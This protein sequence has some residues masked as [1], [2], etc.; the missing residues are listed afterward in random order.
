M[1]INVQKSSN[2]WKVYLFDLLETFLV[3]ASSSFQETA[4]VFLRYL[5]VLS[6][7]TEALA[8]WQQLAQS[9]CKMLLFKHPLLL[10]ILL[11]LHA[12]IGIQLSFSWKVCS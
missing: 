12:G 1:E 3:R 6:S 11:I 10:Y 8:D 4:C 7:V 9:G 2:A 5:W